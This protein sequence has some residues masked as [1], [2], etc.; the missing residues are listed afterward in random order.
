M[1]VESRS[2]SHAA[3]EFSTHYLFSD[4]FMSKAKQAKVPKGW[5]A[6]QT[7]FFSEDHYIIASLPLF[8]VKSF[9]Y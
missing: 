8:Y 4:D 3:A 2:I 1:F 9:F 5:F 7:V 6:S